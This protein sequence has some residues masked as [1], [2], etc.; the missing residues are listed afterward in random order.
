MNIKDEF[1]KLIDDIEDETLVQSYY[2]LFCHLTKRTEGTLLHD[3]TNQ[4]KTELILSYI[5]SHNEENLVKHDQV[6]KEYSRW[7]GK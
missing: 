7:L 4:E 6:I 2:E 5:E 3:L 1:H